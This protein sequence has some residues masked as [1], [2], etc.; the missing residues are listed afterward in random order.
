MQGRITSN[1]PAVNEHGVPWRRVLELQ[2]EAGERLANR[3]VL[4]LEAWQ[5]YDRSKDERAPAGVVN[6]LRKRA[7]ELTERALG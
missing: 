7:R 5:V 3:L 4:A 1:D 6:G 2:T